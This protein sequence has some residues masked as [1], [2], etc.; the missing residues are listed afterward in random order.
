M[1]VR[2]YKYP[3]GPGIFEHDMP[4]DAEILCFQVQ[5]DVPCIWAR[6]DVD[7]PTV[8]RKF[9]LVGTGHVAP[10][11]GQAKYIGTCQMYDG[12]LVWHLFEQTPAPTL[13]ELGEK[14][15]AA[16]GGEGVPR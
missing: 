10:S 3:A 1:N 9:A 4:E 8:P 14:F 6:V 13:E 5:Q 7:A 11:L 12:T 2:V 15:M 16:I